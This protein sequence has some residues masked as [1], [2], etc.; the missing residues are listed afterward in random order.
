MIGSV[1]E[2]DVRSGGD[3]D[4]RAQNLRTP[5]RGAWDH[6]TVTAIAGTTPRSTSMETYPAA[7][8]ITERI[9]DGLSRRVEQQFSVCCRNIKN[10]RFRAMVSTGR[11]PRTRLGVY[12]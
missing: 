6:H 4:E 9:L 5:Q 8:L 7:D 1:G 3:V 2:R 12:L 10:Q 11:L